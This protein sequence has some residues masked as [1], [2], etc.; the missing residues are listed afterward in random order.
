MQNDTRINRIIAF[1]VFLVSTFVYLRTISPTV[2]FWD[3]GEFITCSYILGVPHPPGAP[4]YILVGRIFSMIPFVKD[5]GMRVNVISSLSSGLTIMLVYLIIVR[6]ITMFKGKP[7]DLSN[8][9]IL[10]ASGVIGALT[11]AF[12]DSFWFNAVEAEVYAISICFTAAVIWRILVWYEKAD[13]PS[14][15]KYILLI[16]Y[17]VGLV[18][19]IHL[20]SILAL[21][22]VFAVI[23]FRKNKKLEW[24]NFWIFIAVSAVA[25]FAIY[26][27]IVKWIPNLAYYI[28]RK[29]SSELTTVLSIIFLGAIIYGIYRFY[30]DRNRIAFLALTS[31]FLILLATSTYTEIYIRSNLNPAIDENDPQNM[32][33]M[34]SY[35][36]R[37]Q[38]GDWGIFPRRYPGLVSQS[39]FERRYPYSNYATHDLS[40]QLSFMWNYQI[41]EMFL[42]Y[43]DWQFIGQGTTLDAEGRIKENFSLIGLLGIPFLVGLIGMF[44]HFSKDWK[45]ASVIMLL[46]IMTGIAIVIYLNQEDPQPRERDYVYVGAFLAFAVW[47]GIGITAIGDY[48]KNLTHKLPAV[49]KNIIIAALVLILFLI[50]PVHVISNN[51]KSH[52]RSG[53]YVAYDYS[54]N[55]LQSCEPN[56]ILFTNGDNDTFPLWFLQFVY[57]IR[58]DVRVVNLSLLN[59]HWYIKQL[60]DE[61]PKVPIS[62]N[63]MQIDRLQAEYWPEAKTVRLD[64]PKDVYLHDLGEE[65]E[66][67]QLMQEIDQKP[68]I[69]FELKPTLDNIAIRVQDKMILDIIHTNRFQKPVYFALTV[70]QD[71]QLNLNNYLRMDGLVFKL[72][73]YPTAE[74]PLS[75]VHLKANLFDKFQYRNLNNKNVYYDDNIKG[76][77]RNYQGSFF[78]L[79]QYYLREKMNDQMIEVLDKLS[80]VMPDSVIP[81]RK[82][83]QFQIGRMYYFAGQHDKFKQILKRLMEREDIPLDERLQY[84]EA[85]IQIYPDEKQEVENYV[86]QLYNNYPTH[87]ELYYWLARYYVR[88]GEYQQGIDI[89]NKWL[90]RNPND[91]NA[92][93]QIEQI[94]KLMTS[95]KKDTAT[96]DTTATDSLQN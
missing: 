77:L 27:G 69:V 20:L 31:F 73:T 65:V 74:E 7:A 48:F 42:R 64:V 40:K 47:I 17:L 79:A 55:I 28:D 78:S 26:P 24:K 35:L 68:Q 25:F 96:S 93:S 87:Q 67:K 63:D 29:T 11:Y 84:A 5:I 32:E 36:N 89:L 18:I 95:A 71:N 14:S 56:A 57:N 92:I 70:S 59:T 22:A 6:L 75:P 76:L 8:R 38:Y 52:D 43:F 2:S 50:L 94:Q 58:Q 49:Q 82:E 33:N 1:L 44:F 37:E 15:D 60:R 85:T 19:G 81:I 80:T 88:A 72:L 51:Y 30:K 53:N 61:E 3:C 12:T 66:R 39:E 4:L 46:F 45:H 41:K 23:Y 91:K 83:L 62:L 54:Y 34:V 10:Y 21:P 16:A 86:H 13:D 90:V 9:I